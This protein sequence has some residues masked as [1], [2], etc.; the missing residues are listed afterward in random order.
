MLQQVLSLVCEL[1]N[2][3]LAYSEV[4]IAKTST[5]MKYSNRKSCNL[6]LEDANETACKGIY[7]VTAAV[8]LHKSIGLFWVN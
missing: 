8:S 6:S 3:I 5:T 1:F 7:L 4:L 2:D